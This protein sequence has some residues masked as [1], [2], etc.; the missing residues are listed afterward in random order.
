MNNLNPIV[1]LCGA[2]CIWPILVGVIPTWFF[3][4]YRPQFRFPISLGD[5]LEGR[6]VPPSYRS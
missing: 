4:R 2:C 6:K 5:R 1:V 3:M